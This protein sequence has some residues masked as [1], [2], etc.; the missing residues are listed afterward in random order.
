[1]ILWSNL[2]NSKSREI[3]IL[4][5][6]WALQ[7]RLRLIEQHIY[8]WVYL[9]FHFFLS[10][11]LLMARSRAKHSRSLSVRKNDSLSGLCPI[12]RLVRPAASRP[13]ATFPFPLLSRH[14]FLFSNF[15]FFLFFHSMT[16]GV[17]KE[18]QESES[19]EVRSDDPD[20]FIEEIDSPDDVQDQVVNRK[21]GLDLLNCFRP[22]DGCLLPSKSLKAN[23]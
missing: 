19:K 20:D 9:F 21:P 14:L 5:R 18:L 8:K 22:P 2:I 3:A 23:F 15:R 13:R 1:M 6:K 17:A 16:A 10:S 12:A 7:H 11:G 4:L